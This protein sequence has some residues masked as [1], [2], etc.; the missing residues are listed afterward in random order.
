MILIGSVSEQH[1][2][3][4]EC[5]ASGY[6]GEYNL[7]GAQY[8]QFGRPIV[9]PCAD[10]DIGYMYRTG[11]L[12]IRFFKFSDPVIEIVLFPLTYYPTSFYSR[13]IRA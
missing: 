12:Y 11:K 1:Q 5:L 8:Y 10:D 13:Y 7:T 6:I 3:L 9:L 2:G 4:G